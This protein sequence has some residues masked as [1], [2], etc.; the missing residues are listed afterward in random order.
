MDPSNSWKL[1]FLRLISKKEKDGKQDCLQLT[2]E[3]CRPLLC[4]CL[5]L[6]TINL[7]ARNKQ[8]KILNH[9]DE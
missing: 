5:H 1:H 3:P 2:M 6:G 4:F 8:Q 9:Q 7:I